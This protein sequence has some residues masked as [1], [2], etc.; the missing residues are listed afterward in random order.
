[1]YPAPPV[2]RIVFCF[3]MLNVS[4][5]LAEEVAAG[6]ED[7]AGHVGCASERCGLTDATCVPFGEAERS[8]LG[9]RAAR[10]L[11]YVVCMSL[12]PGIDERTQGVLPDLEVPELKRI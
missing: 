10:V 4:G 1:M 5:N 8:P 7:P 3:G 12:R 11:R 9:A 6:V 2:T